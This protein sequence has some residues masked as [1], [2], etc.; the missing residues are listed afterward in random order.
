MDRQQV[1]IAL[2][3]LSPSKW[4]QKKN[5]ATYKLP[6]PYKKCQFIMRQLVAVQSYWTG[7]KTGVRDE[8]I[9]AAKQPLWLRVGCP[10]SRKIRECKQTR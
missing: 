7:L 6:D 2:K 5:G 3:H 4:L 8:V 9:E 1:L 10:W